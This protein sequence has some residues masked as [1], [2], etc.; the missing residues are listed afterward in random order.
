MDFY[1]ISPEIFNENIAVLQLG[2]K[3]DQLKNIPAPV[4]TKLT[5]AYNARHEKLTKGKK[6]KTQITEK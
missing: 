5:K 6:A 4:K 1:H 3:K 2:S